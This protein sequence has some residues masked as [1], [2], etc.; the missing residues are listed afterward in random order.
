MEADRYAA[1]NLPS[2]KERL[3]RWTMIGVKMSAHDFSKDVGNASM[4][5]DLPGNDLRSLEISS[6]LTGCR[7]SRRGPQ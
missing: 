2:A 5:D 6:A 1:G 3:H 4:G 7:T